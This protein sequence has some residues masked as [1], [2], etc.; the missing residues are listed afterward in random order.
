MAEQV[1][2]HAAGL[3]VVG[4]DET[5]DDPAV[6]LAVR[7]TLELAV[8]HHQLRDEATAAGLLRP[9]VYSPLTTLL[10][11]ALS[12]P[13]GWFSQLAQQGSDL[14]GVFGGAAL[15]VLSSLLTAFQSVASAGATVLLA[16][17]RALAP[18]LPVIT[19][20][21]AQLAQVIS[22]NLAAATPTLVAIG[23]QLANAAVTVLNGLLLANAL[24]GLVVAALGLAPPLLRL[25]SAL[26]PGHGRGGASG[27]AWRDRR[28]C[29]VDHR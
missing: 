25:A 26:L 11:N 2:A 12:L 6:L 20:A 28:R 3:D 17:L 9:V 27:R 16:T 1:A 10:V 21:V 5:K 14:V 22:A 15:D 7:A 23:Q 18:S 8:R 4:F 13:V 29:R 24:L 19:S